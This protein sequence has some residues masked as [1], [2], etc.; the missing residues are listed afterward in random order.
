MKT[1][2]SC[3][4]LGG[5][6][7][8]RML[9]EILT[10]RGIP[11]LGILDKNY[12]LWGT[13]NQGVPI[14]GGDDLLPELLTQAKWFAIGLGGTGNNRPRQKLFDYALSLGCEPLSIIHPKAIVSQWTEFGNGSQLLPGCII[15]VGAVLGKNVIINSGAIVEHDCR[16]GDHAHIASGARLASTVTIGMGAHIGAGATI[17]QC[18]NIGSYALVA[19]GAVVVKDV[20]DGKIVAGIPAKPLISQG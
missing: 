10:L 16:I 8:A 13:T 20:P 18:I 12:E 5:G 1:I 15:N 17:R 3:I 14:L 6:G 4:I 19:A 9:I 2:D 11:I 7:H